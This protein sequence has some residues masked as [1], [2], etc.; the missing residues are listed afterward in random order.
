MAMR[1][2]PIV[3]EINAA[4]DQ[5]ADVIVSLAVLIDRLGRTAE[6][7]RMEEQ[8]AAVVEL[9]RQASRQVTTLGRLFDRQR[10][11]QSQ[12]LHAR[13]ERIVSGY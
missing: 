5:V 3:A 13:E 10:G 2:E 11:L 1:R 12:F 6:A 9:C 8:H 4:S 7:A